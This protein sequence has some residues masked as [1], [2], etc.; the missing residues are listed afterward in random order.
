MTNDAQKAQMLEKIKQFSSNENC[1]HL[2]SQDFIH[3]LKHIGLPHKTAGNLTSKIKNVINHNDDYDAIEYRIHHLLSGYDAGDKLKDALSGR[4]NLIYSQIAPYLPAHGR[5]LDFGCGD[6]KVSYNIIQHLPVEMHAVDVVDYH[7]HKDKIPFSLL[8]PQSGTGFPDNHFDFT[9]VTNVLHHAEN[10]EEPIGEIVRVT[11]DK[12][13]IVVIE[14]VPENN[15]EQEYLRTFANDWFYNRP[16]H[17]GANVPV[18]GTYELAEN[19]PARFKRYGRNLAEPMTDLH[20]D[21]PV[22]RDH[23]VL[24]VFS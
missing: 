10:N 4:A 14:T 6:G 8:K 7:M 2:I 9:I 13:L 3:T 18:P 23:H 5:G 19:W 16:L 1:W 11:K 20:I 12:G 15:S 22:I 17:H 24:Y 21:Q